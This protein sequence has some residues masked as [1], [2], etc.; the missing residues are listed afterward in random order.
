MKHE[1][2]KHSARTLITNRRV[3]WR[4]RTTK[5]QN[6]AY[7]IRQ[8]CLSVCMTACKSTGQVTI[9]VFLQF[10]EALWIRSR[11]S[12]VGTATTLRVG[13]PRYQSWIPSKSNRFL[14]QDVNFCGTM[15]TGFPRGM[16]QP[17][18]EPTAHLHFTP[19]LTTRESLPPIPR[20]FSL[21]NA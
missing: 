3:A 17:R 5:L 19:I 9:K 21:R 13:W 15:V 18:C 10:L 7:Y 12:Y 14:M 2:P 4:V 11:V 6:K 16:N 20:M 1:L 8:V